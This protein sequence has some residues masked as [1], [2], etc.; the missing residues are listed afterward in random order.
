MSTRH[1]QVFRLA[2][3]VLPLLALAGLD[4]LLQ[5]GGWLPP[6][7]PLLFYART[8]EAGF[9]PFEAAPE[10]GLRIRPDWQADGGLRTRPG[11]GGETF[12]LPGFRAQRIEMPRPPD[13]MR[14]F[15]LGGSTV[16][17]LLVNASQS[18]PA[19]LQERLQ[20]RWPQRRIQVHN[21][22]CPGWASDRVAALLPQLLRLDPHLVVIYS[23]HN[24]L[25]RQEP[26]PLASLDTLG[27]ARLF[28]LR[29]SAL[30]QWG[31]HLVV[32]PSQ[33]AEAAQWVQAA[34]RWRKGEVTSRR[35]EETDPALRM[36]LLV[37]AARRYAD[38][39]RSMQR[40]GAAAGVP[41]YFVLPAANL[42]HAPHRPAH[43]TG[44]SK[45]E[46]FQQALG[47]ARARHV[48]GQHKESM[49][50][51]ERALA[52]SP[53]HALAHYGYGLNLRAAGR[54]DAARTALQRAR[55]LDQWSHRITSGLEKAFLAAIPSQSRLDPRT[56]LDVLAPPKTSAF[57]DHC[58]LSPGGHELLATLLVD[59]LDKLLKATVGGL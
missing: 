18:F 40:V 31:V 42:D 41:L 22:G 47:E 33:P 29:H 35:T 57:L 4:G 28:A 38:N 44:F 30:F 2:A 23:G 53:D 9:T 15:V 59:A 49:V 16:F 27:H 8:F 54:R 3:V 25:L 11:E 7:D 6:E 46:A 56:G 55:D 24:E 43:K 21:L 1:R 19:R 12:I 32:P 14:V 58:H 45:H 52:L 34:Q 39:L 17:G 36:E 13:V 48:A 20:S 10:G 37:S 26:E 50:A 51:V 5:A